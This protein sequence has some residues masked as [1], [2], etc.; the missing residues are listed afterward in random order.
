[1]LKDLVA[2]FVDDELMPLEAGVLAREAEG[3]G[4]GI[5]PR[6]STRGS[7]RSP[8][9]SASGA[10]TRRRTSAASDLPA[11]A[12]VGVNEE[13]GRTRHAL[14][15]AA[16]QPEPAHA[17][18]DGERAPARGLSGALRRAARRSR[19]SASP[20]PAPA[21]I[22]AGMI[23]RAVRDGDDWVINGRKIWISRADRRRL[24]H[25]DGGDRQGEARARRH[26]RLPGRQGHAGLQRAA[27]H[28][29]DRRRRRPTRSRWR[30]AGSRAGSCSATEGAG[31]APMQTAARHAAAPDGRLVDRH[32]AAGAGHDRA[33]TRRSAMTFGVP[34]SRAPGDPVVGGRRGD[35]DPRRA[36]DDLRLRLEA[37]PGP[38]RAPGDL[39][40][41]GLRHRDGLRDRRPRHADL[42]RHGHDQGTAAA[43]DVGQAAHHAHL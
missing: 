36:A 35:Q 9:S 21:P 38:R 3:Q 16:G 6:P 29:D 11:V 25:P 5:G 28:P 31:F 22:P 7:T 15:P 19:R 27:P 43:A 24:H 40:D 37:R 8:T 33:S 17:D 4:L 13:L 2:R 32:G 1:M 18:G 23:T 34:L 10:W 30:T 39:D 14:H 20:S 26:L 42:R 41:Q 12:M